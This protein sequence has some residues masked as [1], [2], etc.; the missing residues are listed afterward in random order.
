MSKGV[1][2]QITEL[3]SLPIADLR[4]RWRELYQSEPPAYRRDA[5]K[6]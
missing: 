6:R 4:T 1:L 2:R 5:L 3:E